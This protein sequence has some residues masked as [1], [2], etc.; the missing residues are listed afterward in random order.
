MRG[1]TLPSGRKVILSDTVGFIADLPPQLVA[2]FRATLEEVV[3]ADILL[4]VRDIAHPD[5]NAQR[6]D[7]LA[8]LTDLGVADAEQRMIEVLNKIDVLDADTRA[9]VVNTAARDPRQVALSAQTGE[10]IDRLMVALERQMA[11]TREVIDVD[12]P[13]GDGQTLAWLYAKG[14]VHERQD[15][16]A[17]AHIRVGLQ[18]ADA[19]RFRKR[20][21][22]AD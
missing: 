11:T 1:V 20:K 8:V 3:Q 4:H 9:H 22:T 6:A 15:D 12:V 7:V 10:G 13:L 5:T 2:A 18:P 19:G 21:A 17:I 16:D 14:V